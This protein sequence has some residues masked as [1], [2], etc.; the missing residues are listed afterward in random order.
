MGNA[1]CVNMDVIIYKVYLKELIFAC[2][3]SFAYLEPNS[4]HLNNVA[5]V[6]VTLRSHL[7]WNLSSR[8]SPLAPLAGGIPP[9]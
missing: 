7:W 3:K 5:E 4:L 6:K 9:K 1:V 8:G 2:H